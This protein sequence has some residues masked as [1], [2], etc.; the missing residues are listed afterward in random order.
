MKKMTINDLIKWKQEGRK[1]ATSTAYDAS[2]AQLFESQ[3]MPVL[4]VGDSLGMVLQGEN[5]TLPV[6]VDDIVYHTRCV[7]TGSPNCLLMADMPFMSYA[8]PE[9]ACENAAKL[10]RAGANM[11][12]IEG[13]D[14]LV[15]TVKMLTERAVP[16][17]AHLGL[18]PQSVNIFGGYK[19]QG[20][21]QEKADRMVKDALAL[22]EA[23]AQIVLLECVPAEL[24]E[25]IT[26]VLDVPVIGIGAGNVTDGQILVMHDMFGISANY[27]PK[28]SKN[29][30][31][32]TGDMRKAVAKYIEDVANGVFPDDAHT[33]A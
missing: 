9:Q 23:G 8:T 15:D 32:E 17:C 13:G 28:F 1:F 3:E 7:R 31:A 16:V 5:D 14:W 4:L 18:T 29:F 25:R 24:A 22:Q 2:F 30:L 27:M 33:I 10:M 19:I 6:T 21:D 26:K 12:K 20:R 11:V